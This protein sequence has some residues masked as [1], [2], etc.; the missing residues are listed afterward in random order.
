MSVKR[1]VVGLDKFNQQMLA[2]LPQAAGSDL[3]PALTLAEMGDHPDA[4]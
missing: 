2:T 4:D 1:P 3:R